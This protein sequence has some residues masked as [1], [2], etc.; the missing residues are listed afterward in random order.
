MVAIIEERYN[1]VALKNN[2]RQKSSIKIDALLKSVYN[3]FH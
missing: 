3:T 1:E 2:N